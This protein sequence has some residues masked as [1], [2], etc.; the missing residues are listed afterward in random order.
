MNLTDQKC[1]RDVLK[2]LLPCFHEH[3]IHFRQILPQHT[4]FE[5]SGAMK[6]TYC[7]LEHSK[8][9]L[10]EP[11]LSACWP[12][13]M[14][15]HPSYASAT[16][17]H[18]NAH[19]ECCTR[20]FLLISLKI[21]PSKVM[22]PWASKVGSNW[23]FLHLRGLHISQRTYICILDWNGL[24]IASNKCNRWTLLVMTSM[25]EVLDLT[26]FWWLHMYGYGTTARNAWRDDRKYHGKK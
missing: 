7:F 4:I 23:G 17:R 2:D 22:P 10:W 12:V 6:L 18:I 1:G 9:W 16:F 21:R 8:F 25:S 24:L 14:E 26:N 3:T 20:R 15:R 19:T 13:I 5:K 11:V